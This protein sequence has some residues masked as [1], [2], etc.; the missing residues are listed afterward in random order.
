MPRTIADTAGGRVYEFWSARQRQGKTTAA[1]SR[2]VDLAHHASVKGVWVLDRLGEWRPRDLPL[3][4]CVVC[5]SIGEF[6]ALDTFPRCVIWHLGA[7]AENYQGVLREA[8]RVGDI[9]LVLDEA[10]EF[11]PSGSRWTGSEELRDIV[12]AGAHLARESDGEMRPTHLIVLTQYPKTVHHL[13]WAQAYVVMVGV[14]SGSQTF[15]WLRENF[16]TPDY[17]AEAAVSALR[18]YEWENVRGERPAL[19]GYGKI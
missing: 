7:N 13:L 11:A 6:E 16:S 5:H 8:I 9:A 18:D 2:V 12:L 10:Y 3:R 4:S 14:S 1:R 19:P 15:A 17:D